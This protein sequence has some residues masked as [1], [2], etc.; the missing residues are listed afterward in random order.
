MLLFNQK[1]DSLILVTCEAL[2]QMLWLD[3]SG[4]GKEFGLSWCLPPT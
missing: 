4:F 3:Y 1:D 2:V